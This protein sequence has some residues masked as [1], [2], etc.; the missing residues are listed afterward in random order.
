MTSLIS[1]L[2]MVVAAIL[3]SISTWVVAR[4]LQC[5]DLVWDDAMEKLI[6]RKLK[7]FRTI[8]FKIHS[9]IAVVG[10]I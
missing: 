10:K 1:L 3:A 2:V 5:F 7:V 6:M 8:M 4:F 9:T